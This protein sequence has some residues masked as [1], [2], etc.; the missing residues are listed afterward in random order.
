MRKMINYGDE[1]KEH[2]SKHNYNWSRI[3]YHPYRILIIRSSG[4][5]KRNST[6]LIK[7]IN[8]YYYSI[9]NKIH[10][11]VKDRYEARCQYLQI[12][13][14][15]KKREKNSSWKNIEYS[16]KMQDVYRNVKDYNL[17]RK[18]NVLIVFDDMVAIWLAT[19]NLLQ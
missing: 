13:R 17:S 1:R 11:Y 4:S 12:S 16:D 14:Y 7:Q 15:F 5:G 18:F 2:V 6:N 8:D 10:F 9:V 19:K 3:P